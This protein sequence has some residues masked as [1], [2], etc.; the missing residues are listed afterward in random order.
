LV[1]FLDFVLPPG[2]AVALEFIAGGHV[3]RLG[4]KCT[5]TK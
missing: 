2:L 5:V 4:E 1:E 3:G